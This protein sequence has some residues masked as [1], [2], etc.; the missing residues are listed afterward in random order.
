[1]ETIV[2]QFKTFF[3]NIRVSLVRSATDFYQS[4][5]N[6]VGEQLAKIILIVGIFLI[7]YIIMNA[8]LNRK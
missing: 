8:F 6:L 1:M 7:I 4:I 2:T 5:C 3:N